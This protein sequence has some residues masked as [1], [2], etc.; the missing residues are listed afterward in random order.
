MDAEFVE[1]RLQILG[2]DGAAV[3]RE[4]ILFLIGEIQEPGPR[5]GVVRRVA[6]FTTV[7]GNGGLGGMGPRIDAS[8]VPGL[9]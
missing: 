3:A 1:F 9:V 5:A 2:C 4:T 8:A 7:G 6:I